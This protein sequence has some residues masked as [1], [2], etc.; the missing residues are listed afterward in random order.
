MIPT[1]KTEINKTLPTIPTSLI[2]PKAFDALSRVAERIPSCAVQNYMFEC[3]LGNKKNETVDIQFTVALDS[4][5]HRWLLGKQSPNQKDAHIKLPDTAGWRQLAAFARHWKNLESSNPSHIWIGLDIDPQHPSIPEPL[6][7]IRTNHLTFEETLGLT[8]HLMG[9]RLRERARLSLRK[10]FH[11]SSKP[12]HYIGIML[13]RQ[14]NTLRMVNA[15]PLYS[16]EKYLERIDWPRSLESIRP[17]LTLLEGSCSNVGLSLDISDRI[18]SYLG[19]EIM[20]WDKPKAT[21]RQWL[22]ILSRLSAAGLCS[23]QEI[24][25][26]A[27]YPG[28]T[29]SEN[30]PNENNT[31][32]IIQRRYLSHLK[33]VAMTKKGFSLKAY[34]G[35]KQDT[36]SR[37]T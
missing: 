10:C 12:P 29:P 18:E 34:L 30:K 13:G 14:V 27:T 23:Q 26:L 32:I 2:T 24:E 28:I 8:E 9:K 37:K 6:I 22:E 16:V 15:L 33:L 3:R 20:N 36:L 1:L 7:H 25:A 11:E 35:S 5:V 17:M 19:M 4:C 21:H 31:K